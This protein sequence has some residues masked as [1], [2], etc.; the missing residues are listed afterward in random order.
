MFP[1]GS[2][3][4]RPSSNARLHSRYLLRPS[5]NA[6]PLPSSN[7]G[8]YPSS[9]AGLC[10]Q[11]P[12]PK[13]IRAPTPKYIRAP[14]PDCVQAPMPDYIRGIISPWFKKVEGVYPSLMPEM[15][16]M[17]PATSARALCR[18]ASEVVH[19]PECGPIF[20][21]IFCWC[22]LFSAEIYSQ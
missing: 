17:E 8:M 19:H 14:T 21:N 11:A 7:T 1:G 20:V 2:V 12:T 6:R 9:N 4:L 16:S 5:T 18:A 10:I 3:L 13:Y 22:N 15:P